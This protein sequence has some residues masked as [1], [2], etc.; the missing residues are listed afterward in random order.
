MP[1]CLHESFRGLHNIV[2]ENKFARFALSGGG[3]GCGWGGGG[4]VYDQPMYSQQNMYSP[5]V[6]F[7]IY[8]SLW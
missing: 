2:L 4:E 8:L 3:W 5:S 7:H 6:I 1:K